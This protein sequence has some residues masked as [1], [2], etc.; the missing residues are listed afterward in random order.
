MLTESFVIAGIGGMSGSLVAFWLRTLL[1]GWLGFRPVS[2][3]WRVVSFAVAVTVTTG[4]APSAPAKPVTP[5]AGT[6]V[7]PAADAAQDPQATA[8]IQAADQSLSQI[9]TDL[10]NVDQAA[11]SGENDVPSN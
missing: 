6:P 3:D 9:E 5:Q 7:A 10:S 1:P 8:D 11:A 4:T 2:M